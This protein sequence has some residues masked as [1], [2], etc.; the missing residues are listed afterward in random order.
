MPSQTQNDYD[1]AIE[2][3][4]QVTVALVALRN[5]EKLDTDWSTGKVEEAYSMLEEIQ[6]QIGKFIAGINAEGGLQ[7]K[8]LA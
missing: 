3:Y 8:R 2:A 4:G 5:F 6:G 1:D 7:G